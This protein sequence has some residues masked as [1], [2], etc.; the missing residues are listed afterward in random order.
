MRRMFIDRSVLENPR[1]AESTR[2][3]TSPSNSE[4]VRVP[5]SSSAS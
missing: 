3:T 5:S 4:T 2:R 1:P